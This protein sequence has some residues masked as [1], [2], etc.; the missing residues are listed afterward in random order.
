[1]EAILSFLAALNSLTPLAVI[2]LLGLAIFMLVKGKTVKDDFDGK[3][4]TIKTNDLHEL[5]EMADTLRQILA[6]LQR[7]EV[8]MGK[9]FSHIKARINGK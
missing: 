8:E 5:P 2:A 1:M 6:T 7:M 4:H 9:E 3:L